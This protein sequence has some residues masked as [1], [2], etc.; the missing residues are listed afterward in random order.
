MTIDWL[1]F[2]TVV[3]ASLVSACLVVTLFSLGLRLGDG[4]AAWRR[5]V[6]VTMFVLCG[7]AVVFGLYLIVGDHL[8]VL[9]GAA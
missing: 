8:M 2:F 1:A 5:P 6:S 3:I 9:F 4:K 7:I